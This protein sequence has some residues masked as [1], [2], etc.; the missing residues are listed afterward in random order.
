MLFGWAKPVPVNPWQVRGGKKGLAKVSAAGP[1]SNL[2]LAVIAGIIYRLFRLGVGTGNP[3]SSILFFAVYIN[4]ILAI[5]NSLPIPPLDGSKI[6]M[7]YLPDNLA[8][9]FSSLQQYG[10][11]ILFFLLFIGLFDLIILP[12]AKIL[13]IL[14]IGPP[15][16]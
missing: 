12:I 13:L 15:P 16:Y 2:L 1:G 8:E 10:F 4:I 3:V 14:I 9:R 5:F 6:L 11:L 7:A